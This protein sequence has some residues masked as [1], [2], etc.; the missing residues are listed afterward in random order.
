MNVM[1]LRVQDRGDFSDKII[2]Y[3]FAVE[4]Y[5]KVLDIN[6]ILLSNDKEEGKEQMTFCLLNLVEIKES[7]FFNYF[8]LNPGESSHVES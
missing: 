8:S 1:P 4:F 3:F 7:E 2:Y 5:F 6:A